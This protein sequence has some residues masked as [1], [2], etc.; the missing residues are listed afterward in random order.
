MSFNI[1]DGLKYIHDYRSGRENKTDDDISD[2]LDGKIY[3]ETFDG[4]YIRG[5]NLHHMQKE[6]HISFQMN[7]DGVQIFRSTSFSVW[8]IYLTINE[9]PPHVRYDFIFRNLNSINLADQAMLTHFLRSCLV[10]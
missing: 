4:N 7:T 9:L 5:M 3:K 2:V 8:P 10:A 1:A 6:C